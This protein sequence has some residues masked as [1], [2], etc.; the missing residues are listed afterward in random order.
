MQHLVLIDVK[1]K[2]F[3]SL[4]ELEEKFPIT[5]LVLF[6]LGMCHSCLLNVCVQIVEAR[7]LVYGFTVARI[8][9]TS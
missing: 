4:G 5:L 9:P 8:W 3:I 2:P 6:D 1:L 7:D